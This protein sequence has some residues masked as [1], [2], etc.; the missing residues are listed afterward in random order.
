M[1]EQLKETLQYN[2]RKTEGELKTEKETAVRKFQQMN[3]KN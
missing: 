2:R 3:G 1:N